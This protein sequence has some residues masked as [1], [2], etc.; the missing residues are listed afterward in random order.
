MKSLL[1]LI[2]LI[3]FTGDCF[4][5]VTAIPCNQLPALSGSIA[6][7]A[8]SCVTAIPQYTI[9]ALPACSSGE[10]GT[11]AEVTNGISSPTYN[12][13]VSATGS[14]HDLVFCNGTGWTY[15]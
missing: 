6:T 4:A 13:S 14:T 10:D 3:G 2:A 8:G 7:S 11:L 1:V 15:H 5:Q 12:A 9:S